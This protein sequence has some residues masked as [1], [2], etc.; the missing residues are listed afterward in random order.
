LALFARGVSRKNSTQTSKS[1]SLLGTKSVGTDSDATTRSS[2][3][4]LHPT[5]LPGRFGIGDFGPTAYTWIDQLVRA[6][7]RWW[8]ILPLGPTGYGD[9]PYQSF[10]AF[11]GNPLLISPELLVKDGL[12]RP[13]DLAAGPFRADRV[14]FGW[15]VDWKK[16]LLAR[17]WANFQAKR[18]G[19]LHDAVEEF[20]GQRAH[21][22]ED[23]SLFMALKEAH[24]GVSW[25]QWPEPIRLREPAAVNDARRELAEPAARHRFAQFL[26]FRQW[27]DLKRQAKERGI[28]LIGDLPIFVSS[29]SADV[30]A[31][32]ELFNLDE[33]R[34][35][36]VVAGVPPD[37]FSATGQ[38]W[39]N[40]LYDWE[41]LKQTG[42]RWWLDR[43]VA[44]LEQVDV[45]RLDHFR[46]FEAY[47][48]VPASE[49]TAING[50]W[51]AGPGADFF[52][53]A[54]R[55][56]GRLPLIAEDLGLITPPVDALRRQFGLPGMRILQ[57]GF[58][59]A[60]EARF[61]P[62][63]FERHTVVYT[64]THDND[65]TRGWHAC[66]TDAERD[67]FH[68]YSASTGAD[69]AWDL[70]RLAWSSVADLAIAPLQDVLDLGSE[71]R[72]NYPGQPAGN[73][74]WRFQAPMLT[75]QRLDRLAE[76]TE[77]YDRC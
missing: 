3:I 63:N 12:L 4:L 7:Q 47:W 60:P 9:S 57:F 42:Y 37:Y 66:I 20:S 16:G 5:S 13:D 45:V 30:W 71:A 67:F 23:F 1:D 29:D 28:Q 53:A 50:R 39:G 74:D 15:V 54:I 43:L 64:G 59:G 41:A 44:T 21:W 70:M 52:E 31:N 10:S 48:E 73:W 2:G 38:L 49:T 56:F 69:P 18:D 8:Q 35:P 76:W 40:P 33:H 26:F 25:L 27:G 34:Q 61:L 46:G 17:A 58:G 51:V 6:R 32:P 11:A 77:I 72:M 55:H 75:D 14:I 24:G 62:H 19:V 68:R 36:T 22:L 65:C